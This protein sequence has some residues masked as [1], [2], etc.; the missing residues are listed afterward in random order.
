MASEFH[1]NAVF[2]FELVWR[3]PN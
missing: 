3:Q 2:N 1:S